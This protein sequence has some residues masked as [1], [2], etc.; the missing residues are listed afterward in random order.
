[1]IK[2]EERYK[3]FT[4]LVMNLYRSVQKI[5]NEE[6]ALFGLK[7]NQVQ[8][9]FSLYQARRG[10]N[11][12]KLC[13]LC[14]EDKAAVSRTVKELTERGLV[15]IEEKSTQK[16]K[17]PI[18]LTPKGHA[19]ATFVSDR[20]SSISRLSGLGV[21]QQERVAMYHALSQ[22]AENLNRICENYGDK[23]ANQKPEIE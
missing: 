23:I 8:C 15:S 18:K 4:G 1:M 20:I 5:K 19:F 11:L 17:N 2:A 3:I 22:I 21:S 9:I 10:V 13:E 16:Y 14:H 6:M 12:T 7:G